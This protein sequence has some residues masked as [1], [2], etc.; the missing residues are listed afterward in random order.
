MPT[1]STDLTIGSRANA[2]ADQKTNANSNAVKTL[3]PSSPRRGEGS[4][5]RALR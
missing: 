3:N 2:G 4:L 1:A 5:F